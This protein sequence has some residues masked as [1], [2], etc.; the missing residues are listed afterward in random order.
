MTR[1]RFVSFVLLSALLSACATVPDGRPRLP[2]V[3]AVWVSER[4]P[5]DEIDSVSAW[6]GGNER[7]VV[8]A[9][10][11]SGD[12]LVFLD[13]SS[14]RTLDRFG[15]SGQ[16]PGQ[17]RAPNGIAIDGDLAF[18]VDRDN[19]RV[20]VVNLA[21]KRV[22]GAFGDSVLRRP[23]GLWL[24]GHG[25][26]AFH[27][28]VTDSYDVDAGQSY[29]Q[30]LDGRVKSFAVRVT[31]SGVDA[32]LER[33]F[34]SSEGEGALHYVESIWGDPDNNRL[35]V[36]DEHPDHRDIKI[37]DLGGR[38][39]GQVLGVDL[40]VGE[41][42]GITLIECA[43]GAGYWLVSDQHDSEQAFRLFDR[44]T[45]A[46]VGAFL[47]KDARMVDGLWFRPGRFG[48][49]PAGA[50]FSQHDNAAVIAF[51]WRAITAALSLRDDCG[52]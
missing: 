5:E 40:F 15:E 25:G 36:A 52:G 43:G 24:L 39:T 13:A 17:F 37:F 9:T 44:Q 19:H 45:L 12:R 3:D 41:P 34:G 14:G 30:G 2:S 23:F 27:A 10:A 7:H 31:E 48:L 1:T 18:V 22:L 11:K 33:R 20:Q 42:E 35:L 32:E 47:S 28:F 21:T 29:S 16:A 38:F 46:P 49:F 8:V 6:Q 50:L 51:D 4:M 26:G